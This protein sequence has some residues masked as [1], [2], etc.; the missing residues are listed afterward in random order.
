[1]VKRIKE[2]IDVSNAERESLIK[3]KKLIDES[4]EG[5]DTTIKVVLL[6]E[7]SKELGEALNIERMGI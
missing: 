1:M 4:I 3:L 6:K 7:F 5:K 2:N